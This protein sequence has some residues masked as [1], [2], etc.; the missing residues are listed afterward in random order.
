MNFKKDF[1]NIEQD[2]TLNSVHGN[3]L[4]ETIKQSLGWQSH[5]S[6]C[7]DA[8]TIFL[9]IN[10]ER[11]VV[12]DERSNMFD[13]ELWRKSIEE[14]SK[15]MLNGDRKDFFKK[16]EFL[17]SKNFKIESNFDVK[18]FPEQLL[19]FG[20][21]CGVEV[22]LDSGNVNRDYVSFPKG[23]YVS[24]DKIGKMSYD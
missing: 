5:V 19:S 20:C 11:I 14:K 15:M 10:G 4:F 21:I 1:S 13:D 22:N 3:V 17:E 8:K 23:S 9:N 16:S 6:N 24:S 12:N 7:K 18:Q 2:T